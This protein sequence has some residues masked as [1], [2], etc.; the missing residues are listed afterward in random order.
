LSGSE[1]GI[2]NL[3]ICNLRTGSSLLLGI[4]LENKFSWLGERRSRNASMFTGWAGPPSFLSFR[5]IDLAAKY[6][7]ITTYMENIPE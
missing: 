5:I 3:L 2:C 7:E 4:P 1:E 6:S